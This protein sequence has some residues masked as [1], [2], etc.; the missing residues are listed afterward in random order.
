MGSYGIGVGRLMACIAEEHHDEFGLIWPISVAPFHVALI[1]M[2]RKEEA[3][4]IYRMLQAAGI[5]VFYD[6]RNERP[7]VMFA[8]ADL[9]GFPL[10]LTVSDRSLK[11]GGVEF[12]RRD[13]PEKRILPRETVVTEIRKTMDELFGGISVPEPHAAP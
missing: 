3:E 12:K 6:D 4:E 11:Q 9:M 2:G 7:G 1:A 10:R 8:D 13:F 5:E